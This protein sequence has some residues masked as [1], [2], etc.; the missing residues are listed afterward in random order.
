MELQTATTILHFIEIKTSDVIN[1]KNTVKVYFL[2]FYYFL[3]FARVEMPLAET[4]VT[5]SSA[6]SAESM[7]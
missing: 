2:Y 4:N 7:E 3:T 6:D 1:F 5:I